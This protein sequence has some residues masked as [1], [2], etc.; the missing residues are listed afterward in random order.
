MGGLK[1][2]LVFFACP[3]ISTNT[4]TTKPQTL[5]PDKGFLARFGDWG[6]GFRAASLPEYEY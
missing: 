1:G 5:N 4:Q 6:F 3:L 2:R